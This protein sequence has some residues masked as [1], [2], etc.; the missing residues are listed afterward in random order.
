MRWGTFKS[1]SPAQQTRQRLHPVPNQ[2]IS[3]FAR[4]G[5]C[6]PSNAVMEG[7]LAARVCAPY[8]V[9]CGGSLYCSSCAFKLL[10]FP[11][12]CFPHPPPCRLL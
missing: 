7:S 2:T 9:Q 6:L 4:L 1:A 8:G 12:L 3:V 10:L 5:E 11:P